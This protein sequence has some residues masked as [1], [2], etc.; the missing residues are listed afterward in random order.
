[1]P[2][3]KKYAKSS[4]LC[5]LWVRDLT[6]RYCRRFSYSVGSIYIMK[7]LCYPISNLTLTKTFSAGWRS[8]LSSF[9]QLAAY[10][11]QLSQRYYCTS[12]YTATITESNAISYSM[13]YTIIMAQFFKIYKNTQEQSDYYISPHTTSSPSLRGASKQEQEKDEECVRGVI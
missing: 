10:V 3:I 7:Y 12:F 2:K 4:A 5:I 11:Q 6:L 1:M 8:Y 13:F 9:R